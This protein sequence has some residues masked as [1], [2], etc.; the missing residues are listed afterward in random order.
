VRR[1]CRCTAPGSISATQEMN[2][3][4][5]FFWFLRALSNFPVFFSW[6]VQTCSLRVPTQLCIFAIPRALLHSLTCVTNSHPHTIS[7]HLIVFVVRLRPRFVRFWPFPC[8]L[9]L[10]LMASWSIREDRDNLCVV[11]RVTSTGA[12]L[13][14]TTHTFW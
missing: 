13:A 10:F 9:A 11:T 5:L 2:V 12:P 7:A 14:S 4:F 1:T 8:L 6:I 3:A